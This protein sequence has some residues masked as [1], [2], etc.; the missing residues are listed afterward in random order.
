M[1]SGKDSDRTLGYMTRKDTEVKL[2]R[3]T[4]VK[5]KTPAPVQITAEQILREARER[6]EAE[7][8]PP[9]QKITDST[10]LSDYRLRRRKEFEDQIRRARWNIQ[11]WMK[12]AQW[13]E[14]QKDYARARS[15]WERAIEGDYRNHTLWLKY[16]EFE[17]KNKFVNSARNVWDR[18][19]TLLPRVD[20]LW[21]KYIHMEEILGNIAG[22]RQIF[23]RWMQ[24]S[25]DQ[26]GWLSFIKFELLFRFLR[27][28]LSSLN[29]LTILNWRVPWIASQFH[30]SLTDCKKLG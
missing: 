26:Q 7:I 16:A 22:A 1:A 23:E 29:D 2:P 3:P 19:V 28:G 24:W 9:K 21:Y 8:R 13:E 4:R 15:V 14:S 6:Q 20:Q 17:M 25:P 12:Y 27:I 11:V 18:A 30:A 5:N 10:E